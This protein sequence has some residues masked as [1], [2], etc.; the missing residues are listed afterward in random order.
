[1]V[2]SPA[3]VWILSAGWRFL[4]VDGEQLAARIRHR[5]GQPEGDGHRELAE[6]RKSVSHGDG[7]ADET[8]LVHKSLTGQRPGKGR[9]PQTIRSP[10][11]DSRFSCAITSEFSPAA[12][13]ESGQSACCS[14][15][16]KTSWGMLFI[17]A[18]YASS[19]VGQKPA[20]S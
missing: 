6:E 15:R 19:E 9:T 13:R 3:T 11:A 12:I 8:V 4:P 1:M 10:P 7:L 18:A 17:G 20:I 16:E 5:F 2:N 14:A